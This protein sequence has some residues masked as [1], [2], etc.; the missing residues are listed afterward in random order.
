MSFYHVA[1][2]FTQVLK[3][4]PLMLSSQLQLIPDLP[5]YWPCWHHEPKSTLPATPCLLCSQ[6]CLS[7]VHFP[8][9]QGHQT[10]EKQMREGLMVKLTR[11]T[12]R[13]KDHQ[14]VVDCPSQLICTYLYLSLHLLSRRWRLHTGGSKMFKLLF[15][16]GM[17]VLNESFWR[18]CMSSE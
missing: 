15:Q 1:A 17:N 6:P 11:S 4:N 10:E 5:G 8:P 13:A 14:D 3:I 2:C 7:S 18:I 12:Q 9:P 16:A